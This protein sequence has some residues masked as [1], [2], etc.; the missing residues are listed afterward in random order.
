[1]S[2]VEQIFLW[3]S[4]N[5]TTEAY[6]FHSKIQG[7]VWSSA[8]IILVL[9]MLRIVNLGRRRAG[10][11]APLARYVLLCLT[12]VLTP[13]LLFSRT[14]KEFFLLECIICGGQFLIL[15]YTVIFERKRLLDLV[16]RSPPDPS[17]SPSVASH[18]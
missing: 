3:I 11:K 17:T 10:L 15:L 7:I 8:D 2:A 18:K 12:A 6:L 1:M 9:A 16:L 4:G 14:P 13:L 5:F